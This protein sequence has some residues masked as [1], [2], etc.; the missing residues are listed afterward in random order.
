MASCVGLTLFSVKIAQPLSCC[1]CSLFLFFIVYFIE[2]SDCEV[3][4]YWCVD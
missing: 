2:S 4:H 1:S 3:S